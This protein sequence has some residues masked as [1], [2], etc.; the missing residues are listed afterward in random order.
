MIDEAAAPR[1]ASSTKSAA[2]FAPNQSSRTPTYA[3]RTAG[4]EEAPNEVAEEEEED[5]FRTLD[6]DQELIHQRELALLR[7]GEVGFIPV[8]LACDDDNVGGVE[9]TDG[10]QRRMRDEFEM[11]MLRLALGQESGS[12]PF[13]FNA[14]DYVDGAEL[15]MARGAGR[16]GGA[17]SN[18]SAPRTGQPAGV[19]VSTTSTAADAEDEDDWRNEVAD[20]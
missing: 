17:G 11:L 15:E 19:T 14:A 1:C 13:N 5:E 7:A 10:K 18:S 3:L 20:D 9:L 4:D 16:N 12:V 2:E 6:E 8:L